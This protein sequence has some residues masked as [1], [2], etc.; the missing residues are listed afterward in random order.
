MD[1]NLILTILFGAFGVYEWWKRRKLEEINRQNTWSFY[2]DASVILA[3][4][5]GLQEKIRKYN[6]ADCMLEL[7]KVS[8]HAENLMI[9]Q[10][11]LIN[12][13][14]KITRA[15]IEKWLQSDKIC[16]KGHLDIFYKLA[17]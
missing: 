4:L 10:I 8:S 11:R 1:I 16:G 2:R 7:G 9:N 12:V 15:K 14:E 17:E 6:D 5:Q 13:T 3:A